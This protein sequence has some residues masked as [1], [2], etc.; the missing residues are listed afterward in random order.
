[1]FI[2]IYIRYFIFQKPFFIPYR[3]YRHAEYM[4]FQNLARMFGVYVAPV[5][6]RGLTSHAYD[7]FNIS[8]S[9]VDE[10]IK[11]VHLYIKSKA[12]YFNSV[13]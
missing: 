11:T 1:M 8:A 4:N 10:I 3:D 2:Y 13:L 9:E 6:T 5:V 7:E 12:Y